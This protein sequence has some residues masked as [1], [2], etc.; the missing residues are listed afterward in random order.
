MGGGR[1]MGGRSN[2]GRQNESELRQLIADA[3]ELRRQLGPRSDL[4]RRLGDVI[5]QLNRLNADAL[6]DPSQLAA[7]KHEIEDP[8]RQVELELNRR[9]QAKLGKGAGSPGDGE[10]PDRYRKMIE[11][12]YKRL[13]VRSAEARP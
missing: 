6:A 8:V 12:Y 9:L 11:D 7:L 2:E 10:A 5:A 1:P 4:G 13:S 3:E